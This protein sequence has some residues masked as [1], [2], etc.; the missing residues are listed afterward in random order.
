MNVTGFN[1]DAAAVL[2]AWLGGEA[3]GSAVA[4]VL[5]GKSYPSGRLSETFTSAVEDHVSAINFPGGPKVVRYG[6]GL[7][8]GYG[9][10]SRQAGN[11]D[12]AEETVGPVRGHPTLRSAAPSATPSRSG[13]DRCRRGSREADGQGHP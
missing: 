4:E 2:M 5:F 3:G 7:N 12:P 13:H 6:E 11:R 10:G 1:E 9:L 8:V